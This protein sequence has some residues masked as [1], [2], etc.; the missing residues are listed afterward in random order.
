MAIQ[1]VA[2]VVATLNN[3]PRVAVG[4]AILNG[5]LQLRR[6]GVP[7]REARR[8]LRTG[9]RDGAI[10]RLENEDDAPKY[11]VTDKYG[12]RIVSGNMPL[13]HLLTYTADVEPYALTVYTVHDDD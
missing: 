10:R 7:A 8:F 5:V 13:V 1:D 11:V 9:A 6:T 3:D 12:A 4:R 2:K